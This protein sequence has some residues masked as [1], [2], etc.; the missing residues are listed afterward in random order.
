MT[1]QDPSLVLALALAEAEWALDTHRQAVALA[2]AD[3]GDIDLPDAAPTTDD[4]SQLVPLGP[5]YLARELEQAGLL[6]MADQVAGLFA[7]GAITQPLGPTGELITRFWRQR[8]ERL[9]GTER[10]AMLQQVFEPGVFDRA[11]ERL[12]GA[13]LALADN[14]G[15]RDA[16]E[17]VTLDLALRGVRELLFQ[18]SGGMVAFAAEDILAAVRDAVAFL[19]DP[20]LL[21]AFSVRSMWG[22]LAANGERTEYQ[23][24][25]HVELANAGVTLLTWVARADAGQASLNAGNDDSARL[26]AAAQRWLMTQESLGTS[27]GTRPAPALAGAA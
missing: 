25:Q 14:A 8:R 17:E 27:P 1:A 22:L 4:L 10:T 2:L 23:V 9:S 18:R 26:F 3:L 20:R 21:A 15:T 16:R 19:R 5:L 11:L 24:R 7:S 12:C 13:M 6:P